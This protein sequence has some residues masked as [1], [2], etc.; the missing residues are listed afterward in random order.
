MCIYSVHWKEMKNS[1]C[2]LIMSYVR[3]LRCNVQLATYCALRYTQYDA[4][5]YSCTSYNTLIILKYNA[6][7]IV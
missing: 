6:G 3:E 7:N 2:K 4:Y 1:T 5:M